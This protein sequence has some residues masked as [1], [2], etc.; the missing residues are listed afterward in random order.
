MDFIAPI[1]ATHLKL[2]DRLSLASYLKFADDGLYEPTQTTSDYLED[3]LA[4]DIAMILPPLAIDKA[5]IDSFSGE[6]SDK[7]ECDF[8]H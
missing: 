3:A 1:L 8:T 5:K 4:F 2:K 6:V 7:I